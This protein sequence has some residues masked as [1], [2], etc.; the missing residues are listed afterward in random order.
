MTR[1]FNIR[2]NIWNP[3]F[4]YHSIHNNTLT[5]ITDSLNICLSKFTNQVLTRYADNLNNLN[6]V[7]NLMFLHQN[8]EEFDNHMIYSE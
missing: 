6:S 4:P 7:I 1:D 5:N 8:S 3:Y 2:D